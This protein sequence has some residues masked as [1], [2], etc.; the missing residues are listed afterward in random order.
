[1]L[2]PDAGLACIDP[3]PLQDHGLAVAADVGDELHA[4]GRAQQRAALALLGQGVVVAV[5]RNGQLVPHIAGPLLEDG[6]HLALEKRL[7]EVTGNW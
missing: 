6:F 2:P 7:V 5:V 3:R 1:M 4:A